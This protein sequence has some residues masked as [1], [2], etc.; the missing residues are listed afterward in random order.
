[1]RERILDAA[2]RLMADRGYDGTSLQ[3][4]AD[5]VGIRKPS[6]LYHFATKEALR[7]AALDRLLARWNEVLPQILGR[8]VRRSEERVAAV[9]DELMGFFRAEPARARFLIREL[10]DRP[11]EIRARVADAAAPWLSLVSSYVRLG[12]RVGDVRPTVDPEAFVLH[13]AMLVLTGIATAEAFGALFDDDGERAF[14]EL[15]RIVRSSLLRD[16]GGQDG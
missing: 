12:Q 4:I 9:V 13:S 10:L 11:A 1:M 5:A 15:A 14:G 2:T 16:A 8:S 3:S 7:A 6:V